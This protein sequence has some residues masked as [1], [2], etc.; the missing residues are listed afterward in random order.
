M[1]T[2]SPADSSIWRGLQDRGTICWRQ[3]VT[4]RWSLKSQSFTPFWE[5]FLFYSVMW[6]D[7]EFSVLCS[8]QHDCLLSCLPTTM[9]SD[10]YS[11]G[12]LSPDKSFLLKVALI[13]VLNHSISKITNTLSLFFQSLING[14]T[15]SL[16]SN[17]LLEFLIKIILIGSITSLILFCK[18]STMAFR[19]LNMLSLLWMT[20][21]LEDHLLLYDGFSIST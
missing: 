15:Y 9:V 6:V 3:C 11:S 4:E 10:C 16:I 20:E 7:C 8:I 5:W 21:G 19:V 1:S 12:I 18:I 13:L 2:W 14:P 17:T